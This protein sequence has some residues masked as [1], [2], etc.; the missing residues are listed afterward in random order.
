[1]LK[2]HHNMPPFGRHVE[3]RPLPLLGNAHVQTVLGAFWKGKCIAGP[4]RERHILLDDGDRLA[5]HVNQAQSWRTGDPIAILVHGLSGTHQSGYMQRTARLLERRGWRV[6]R[7]DLRGCGKG[8]RLARRS[9][10]AGCSPDVRA[11]VAACHRDHPQSPLFLIGFSLGGNIVLKLA[12]EVHAHPAPGLTRV[13]AVAP[14]IDLVRCSELIA[15]PRNRIYE[16]HF[17]RDLVTLVKRR[18]RCVPDAPVV[19]FP[20]GLSLRTF[21]ELYTAPQGGFANALDYY[22]RSSAQAYIPRITV[23]T[24][25][26]TARDDPFV[27]VAPFETMQSPAHV[28]VRILPYGGHLGFLG[29]DGKSAVRW[30]EERVVEW[31]THRS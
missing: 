27:A 31:I 23:P 21:D 19:K 24:L 20:R 30:A 7:M 9:Y 15:E 28:D 29:W 12:G 18:Q 4:A 6:E 2:N 16:L 10:N 5:V 14:P 1:M 25:I 8:M 13:A 3:F 17:L 11:V 26:V 22:Q